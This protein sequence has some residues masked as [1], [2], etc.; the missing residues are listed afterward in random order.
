MSRSGKKF[1]VQEHKL[2]CGI[3]RFRWKCNFLR[4]LTFSLLPSRFGLQTGLP[5]R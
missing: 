1:A 5:S 4:Q 3:I 2:H